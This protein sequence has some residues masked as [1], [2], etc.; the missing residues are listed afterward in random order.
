[1]LYSEF[2]IKTIQQNGNKFY[3][4]SGVHSAQQASKTYPRSALR[5]KV[6]ID[7]NA[8][9]HAFVERVLIIFIIKP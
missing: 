7:F 8:L 1:M 9:P 6:S 2:T 5:Y 4:A 3:A